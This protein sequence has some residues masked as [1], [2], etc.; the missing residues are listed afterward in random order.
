MRIRRP[1]RAHPRAAVLLIAL[2]A[3]SALHAWPPRSAN[4]ADEPAAPEWIPA[5]PQPSPIQLAA[6]VERAWSAGDANALA[7]LCDS[8]SVRI[9]LKP[10]APPATAPTLK[11]VAFL[12]HDQLDLVVTRRFSVLRVET[13]TKRGTAKAWARWRGSWGGA[14]G[15]RDVEVVLMAH[16]MGDGTWL[17][18]EIRA[19][20]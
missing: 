9:A 17:L 14:S 10:G 11:A 18:T 13:D 5:T 20:D 1:R 2:L 6:A 19:N 15:D 8:A 12:I 16:G 7:A 3:A 4:A